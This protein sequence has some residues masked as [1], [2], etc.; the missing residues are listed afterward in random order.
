MGENR[1]VIASGLLYDMRQY[2]DEDAKRTL[3][4]S[5]YPYNSYRN[6]I[7]NLDKS[8][9]PITHSGWGDS[10]TR[11]TFHSPETDYNRPTVPSELSVQGFLYGNAKINFDEVKGHSK[12]VMLS[13]KAKDLAGILAGIEVGAEIA[14]QALQATSNA[15]VWFI[16]GTMAVGGSIGAPAFTAGTAISIIGATTAALFKWAQYRY[17]WLTTFRNL[18]APHNFAYYQFSEGKYSNIGFGQAEGQKLRGLN[19]GKYLM[20]GMYSS[21]NPTTGV[22]TQIN[23]LHRERSLYLDLGNHPIVYPSIINSP[24]KNYDKS[25]GNSSLTYLGENGLKQTG[26]S[27]D[28]IRNIASPYSYLKNYLSSQHGSINSIIWLSTGYRGD[29]VNPSSD[30]LSIFGGDTYITRYTLKRKMS[31]FLLDAVDLADKTPFNYYQYNN[32]GKNPKFYVSYNLN[33]DVNRNGSFLPD[34]DDEYNMDNFDTSGNYRTPPS[35]FYLYHYG[36]PSFLCESRINSA[37]RYGK[38]QPD[39]N[40][41][42][43]VGDIGDWTQE[44][45]VSIRRPNQFYYHS[46]YS[47]S[48]ESFRGKITLSP[49]Y[50]PTI[51]EKRNNQPN[52]ILSSMPDNSE[53]ALID[54]WLIYRPLDIFEFPTDFGKLKSISQ[55]ENEAILT[56]FENTNVIYNKVD[57]TNDDGQSPSTTFVG[58]V[59][60]FQRRSASFVNAEI[61]FGGTQNTTS[62]SCEAG[63]F[64]VDAKRGQV[65]QVMPGGQGSEE[66]SATIGGKPS[67]MRNWF[68]QHL[69]FK[70]QKY[71]KDIDIDN[72][73]NGV[74]ISMGWDSRFRRLF[75]TKKDYIPLNENIKLVDGLFYVNDV[76]IDIT[77]TLYFKEV[78]WSTAYS[79]ILGSW[80]SFYDFKPNYYVNHQ[81]Y[82]QTGINSINTD[83]GLW[84]HLLTNKSYLVFYGKKYSFDVE[85]VTKSEQITKKFNN[86]ELWTE[87]KRYHNAYDFAFSPDITFN[88]VMIHNNTTCSG[89]LNL[90]P[91]KNNLFRNRDYPKTN[92]NNTQDILITNKDNFK[93]AFDYFFNRVKSNVTN[94]PFI[95]N[96]EN[97]IEKEVNPQAVSFKGKRLLDRLKG[98]WN[99]VRLKY[100]KD[101]RYHL[102]FKFTLNEQNI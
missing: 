93:W 62:V 39:Q 6:D 15:Q 31:Q 80:M 48:V 2:F 7:F 26:R 73:F 97:Q 98:D 21:T 92:A 30:C 1:S 68:K 65:I 90:I 69:P 75:I 100:D 96:D 43:N 3:H 47:K 87:A 55:L 60:T 8:G 67:G 22:T 16:G 72:N 50:N 86:V 27:S 37:L 18:G 74:G 12:W 66:I 23:N 102:N 10:N 59:S 85:Y 46:P 24:Y 91:Q 9:N 94:Q 78:S 44:K 89:D 13:G 36:V 45:H 101:S 41:F 25:T 88:K 81:N 56:R 40:F 95:L 58:G 11:Y 29:L 34:I 33:K 51:S 79:P 70:I 52:G 35:K 20:E 84:S 83:F 99:L 17:E 57:Y 4:Y 42:P 49:D 32:I 19:V 5:N 61:G 28:I 71:F 14:I 76:Q 53:N 64:H 63:H 82:F 77:N 54:P 38:T